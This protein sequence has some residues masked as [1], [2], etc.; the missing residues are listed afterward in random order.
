[1]APE[2]SA[3]QPVEALQGRIAPEPPPEGSVSPLYGG[4]S[5]RSGRTGC[6]FSPRDTGGG[7][8]P[9]RSG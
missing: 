9:V 7:I 3:L 1:M 4:V 8:A 5:V 6:C 2:G